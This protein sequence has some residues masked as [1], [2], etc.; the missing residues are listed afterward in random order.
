MT[1]TP[2][3]QTTE[4]NRHPLFWLPNALTLSRFVAAAI[5]AFVDHKIQIGIFIYAVLSEFFDGFFARLFK[6][7]STFGQILDPIADKTFV[8]TVIVSSI[9][10]GYMSFYHFLLVGYRDLTVIGGALVVLASGNLDNFKGMA[11][12]FIGK[13]TTTSQFVFLFITLYNREVDFRLFITVTI[14][15]VI[16]AIY[17]V[18]LFFQRGLHVEGGVELEGRAAV[19]RKRE[20]MVLVVLTM[21]FGFTIGVYGYFYEVLSLSR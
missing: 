2:S 12:G 21:A 20:M 18:Y 13:F 9:A 7:Q 1:N 14:I 17:Y 8:L 3:T 10:Q 6:A 16:G 11:P 4:S 5:F 19:A 15:S